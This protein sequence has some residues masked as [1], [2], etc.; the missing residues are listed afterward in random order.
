ML[1]LCEHMGPLSLSSLQHGGELDDL[2]SM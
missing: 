1:G 2:C